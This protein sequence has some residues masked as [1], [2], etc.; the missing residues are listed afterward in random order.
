MKKNGMVQGDA[1]V[2]PIVIT[3]GSVFI[4]DQLAT[5]VRIKIGK[6]S[7]IWPGGKISYSNQKW[8]FP[9]T[10]EQTLELSSGQNEYQVQVQL[11]NGETVGTKP[12]N[13][14]IQ[15]SV[16][17][18]TFGE[19]LSAKEPSGFIELNQLNAYIADVNI[20]VSEGGTTNY[21]D[22]ENKPSINGVE[23]SGNKTGEELGLVPDLSGYA[24]K[25]E[26]PVVPDSLPNP[27]ALT[28]TGAVNAVYDGSQA[29]SVEIPSGGSGGGEGGTDI[30]LGLTSASV[31]QIIKVK[32]VDG[33]GKPTEWEAADVESGGGGG[34]NALRL[35][36]DTTTTED[37]SLI[38]FTEDLDGNP[39]KL[40][41][42][43]FKIEAPAATA[44]AG[45][46]FGV[47]CYRFMG[48]ADTPKY[49]W[50]GAKTTVLNTSKVTWW[51]E[52]CLNIEKDGK[53]AILYKRATKTPYS[54][55]TD[56]SDG[57]T[58]HRLDVRYAPYSSGG[59]I[60]Y[61]HETIDR[62]FFYANSTTVMI[63]TGTKIMI[64]GVDA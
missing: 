48:G 22:L 37:V 57:G 41:K 24:T 35:V 54:S 15:K 16:L 6:Y 7:A 39:L 12:Q 51:G 29:V 5:A 43:I 28:F 47:C 26:I 9:L 32:A 50:D 53:Y 44:S 2:L 21:L 34:E 63:P 56:N 27:N 45:A 49:E 8:F 46:L 13:I 17:R 42:F 19:K 60:Y 23:L 55:G 40:K 33:N 20:E 18:G 36:V 38:E 61:F 30:S 62:I 52:F 25:D 64:W 58:Y 4:T 10:Q 59:G 1:Y 11:Q 31:G 14:F 3:A